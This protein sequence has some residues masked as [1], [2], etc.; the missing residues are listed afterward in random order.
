MYGDKDGSQKGLKKGG[1][2]RN[3]TNRCRHPE[4][5]KNK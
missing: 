4:L 3:K 2:G 1:K 5:R